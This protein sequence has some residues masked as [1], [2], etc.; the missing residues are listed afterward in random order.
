MKTNVHLWQYLAELSSEL[1]MFLTKNCR[2]NQNTHFMFKNFL[3]KTVPFIWQCGKSGSAR[4]VTD[5]TIRRMSVPCCIIKAADIHSQ[6]VIFIAFPLQQWLHERASMLRHTYTVCLV[7]IMFT[8]TVRLSSHE[9][10]SSV[11][12]K[13]AAQLLAGS[14]NTNA[15]YTDTSV[16][17]GSYASVSFTARIKVVT[18]KYRP[19]PAMKT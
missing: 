14:S 16:V 11:Q 6:Y 1:E 2:E 18:G 17:R 10:R 3:P 12:L 15:L 5:D 8:R 19:T 13:Y 4:Q 7:V 9:H